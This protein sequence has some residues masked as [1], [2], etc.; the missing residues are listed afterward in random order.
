VLSL[1]YHERAGAEKYHDNEKN[2][3]LPIAPF[4]TDKPRMESPFVGFGWKS[5]RL[6][7][8]GIF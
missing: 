7:S 5:L 3:L 1:L 6:I 8:T 4:D 2:L